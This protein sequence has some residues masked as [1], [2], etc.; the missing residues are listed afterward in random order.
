MIQLPEG[1]IL[2]K[3]DHAQLLK[4]IEHVCEVA[5]IPQAYL[6]HSMTE[7][8]NEAEIEWV[9]NFPAYRAGGLGGLCLT[10]TNSEPRCMAIVAALLRNFIDARIVTLNT[11]IEASKT[12][13]VPDPTVLVIPNLFVSTA[14]KSMTSWQIQAIYD[15]LL[16]R[17]ITN[18][19]TV[20]Y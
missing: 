20:V 7:V 11:L 8:C 5:N 4:D 16:H 10:G 15:I 17:F 1:S 3:V 13:S 18:K 19:P 6:H 9:R 12:A 2:N 14:G